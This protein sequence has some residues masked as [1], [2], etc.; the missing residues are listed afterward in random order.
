M[1]NRVYVRTDKNGTK[2]YHDCTCQRC[3]GLGASEA[4]KF[5]GMTC[6]ECGGSGISK[7]RVIK[8]YTPEYAKV[9]EAK[10]EARWA[11]QQE[12]LRATAAKCNEGFLAEYFPEGKMYVVANQSYDQIKFLRASTAKYIN[13][14]GWYFTDLQNQFDTVEITPAEAL[15][16]D[17]YGYYQFKNGVWKII[18]TKI[19]ALKPVSQYVGTVGEK[20]TCTAVYNH[21]AWFDGKFGT[22]YIHNFTTLDGNQLVWKTGKSGIGVSMGDTV[23]IEATIKEHIEYKGDRQTSLLRCKISQE[24]YSND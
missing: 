11:K 3:G 13:A 21:T 14:V 9:L 16:I 2:I 10:R 17:D 4:W 23:V 6:Y 24:E 12:E 18:D 8:E 1:S 22:T 15:E 19:K 7:V 5:T 20:F